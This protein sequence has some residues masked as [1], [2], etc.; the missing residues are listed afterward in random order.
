MASAKYAPAREKLKRVLAL[1]RCA[2]GEHCWATSGGKMECN[3][4]GVLG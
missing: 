3:D 4:C 1:R 2:A